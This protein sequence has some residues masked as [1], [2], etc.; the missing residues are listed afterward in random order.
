MPRKHHKPQFQAYVIVNSALL[1][2]RHTGGSRACR[3]PGTGIY[4]S[5][6][7]L[8][9]S[10]KAECSRRGPAPGDAAAATY[11]RRQQKAPTNRAR[12]H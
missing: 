5:S 7:A 4:A 9:S 2:R 8:E 10:S 11:R 6:W 1:C 12:H 3:P